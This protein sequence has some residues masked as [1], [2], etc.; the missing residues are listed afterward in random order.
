MRISNH[1]QR[2]IRS[3]SIYLSGQRAFETEYAR[4]I[5]SSV[6]R[7]IG[8][9]PCDLFYFHIRKKA[10]TNYKIQNKKVNSQR[11][12]PSSQRPEVSA[13]IGSDTMLQDWKAN[14]YGQVT[15]SEKLAFVAK[16]TK[17]P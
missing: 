12:V 10:L 6:R 3:V 8:F 7:C 17:V 13:K 9:S 1:S 14:K 15:K 11:H 16:V 4:N 5:F 2:Q